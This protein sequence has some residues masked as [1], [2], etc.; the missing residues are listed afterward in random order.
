MRC[1][2]IEG[3]LLCSHLLDQQY[4]RDYSEPLKLLIKE[5]SICTLLA[6]K[7]IPF[8]VEPPK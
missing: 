5:S 7:V 2:S 4:F 8:V 3:D 1:V 6:E